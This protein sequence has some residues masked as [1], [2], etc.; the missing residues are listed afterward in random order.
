MNRKNL[1]NTIF[2][3]SLMATAALSAVVYAQEEAAA[4]APE[5][6]AIEEAVTEE[7]VV[8]EAPVE[9]AAEAPL[10]PGVDEEMMAKMQEYGAVNENH[11]VLE[12]FIGSWDYAMKWWMG[13]DAPAEES[14][15][16][17]E[18]TSIMG[19]RF[20]DQ[21]V[22]GMS[23][24]QPYDGRGTLGYNN[25]TKEYTS[26][27][28][29]NMG[30]GIMT[31]TASYDAAAKTMTETGSHSCPISPDGK[32]SF[33]AVTTFIDENTFTYEMYTSDENGN[34]FKTMEIAYNRK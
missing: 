25:L 32:K 6:A 29:D 24:G 10:M 5:E 30:T 3:L 31:S 9:A 2:I 26:T 7:A 34:E 11:K 15:G 22:S 33:R 16:T 4:P 27:W 19:G 13:P 14:T 20:I 21:M 12:N 8:E 17:A 18:I 28:I 23:M 1:K